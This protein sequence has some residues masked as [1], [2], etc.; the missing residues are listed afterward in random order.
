MNTLISQGANAVLDPDQYDAD[1]AGLESK[2]Q[3]ADAKRAKTAA[4]IK[5]RE[6]RRRQAR[7]VHDYLQTQPPM[8]YTPQV[9]NTLVEKAEVSADGTIII[10]FKDEHQ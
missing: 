5:D 7:Q 1:C 9:W 10:S 8:A 4:A 2:Y 6:T 3:K